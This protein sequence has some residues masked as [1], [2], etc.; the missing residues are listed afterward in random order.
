MIVENDSHPASHKIYQQNLQK[1]KDIGMNL[2]KKRC[3]RDFTKIIGTKTT[4][5]KISASKNGESD[6]I[7]CSPELIEA[8]Q[9]L[10]EITERKPI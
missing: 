1:E 5:S 9:H 10:Y 8:K 7:V 4:L 3:F 6:F 2:V